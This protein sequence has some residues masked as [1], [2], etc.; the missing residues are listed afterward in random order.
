MWNSNVEGGGSILYNISLYLFI[1]ILGIRWSHRTLADAKL[2]SMEDAIILENESGSMTKDCQQTTI[3]DSLHPFSATMSKLNDETFTENQAVSMESKDCSSALSSPAEA[4]PPKPAAT[5]QSTMEAT[6]QITA[7][8]NRRSASDSSK[9]PVTGL[10]DVL[11]MPPLLTTLPFNTFGSPDGE[12]DFPTEV[13][14]KNVTVTLECNSVWK[15][16]HSRGTEMILT[17]QGRR[18]FPYCR[19]HL[20]GLEPEHH[21]RLF[22]SIYPSDPYK[23]RWNWATKKW[24]TFGLAENQT[25]SLIQAYFPHN[26]SLKGS[27]WMS[28]SVS[29]YKL[30]LTN[31][32]KPQDNRILLNTMHRY[33]PMLHVIPV[34][35][36]DTGQPEMPIVLGPDSMTFIF[37]QTEF[38]AVTC[39]QN[40]R[41]TQLKIQYNPFAR[42]FKKTEDNQ[43][44]NGETDN[45]TEKE[46]SKVLDQSKSNEETA[47]LRSVISTSASFIYNLWTNLIMCYQLILHHACYQDMGKN[48]LS[49]SYN[50]F[51]SLSDTIFSLILFNAHSSA[52]ISIEKIRPKL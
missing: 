16:F 18:M 21:Y 39:Y 49:F 46:E 19:Y 32:C 2:C 42:G 12:N 45:L 25:R 22:L 14:Q 23:H 1:I 40:S 38:M 20:S 51:F 6:K 24:E 36:G 10:I 48:A 44:L 9:S 17:K 5:P 47:D 37:P 27:D 43:L 50:T 29:F 34:L 52:L 7:T 33:I 28:G 13:I 26:R 41:I 8:S 3:P 31:N 15:Q 11:S 35:D 4:C 30:K